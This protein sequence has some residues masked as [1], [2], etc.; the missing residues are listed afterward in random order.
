MFWADIVAKN[1]KSKEP[2]LV[3][4]AKTPS[5]KVHV[6]A[7]RGVLIHDFIHKSLLERGIKSRYT[8]HFDDFDPMDG[9]PVYLDKEKYQKF[10]GRPL[11]DIPSPFGKGSYSQYYANDF[12]KVFNKLG[13]KPEIIWA[14]ELYKNGIFDKAIKKVLDNAAEIQE[15]YH[16]ISGSQKL[17]NW[18]PFQPVCSKCKKIGT[19]LATNWD[20]KEVSFTCEKDLVVWA[21]GCGYTGKISPFKGNGKM[22]Y[23]VEWA[24]KWFILGITIEGAGKDHS[25]KGGTRDV[26]NTIMRKIFKKE[27]PEDIPYEHIL[28]GGRKMS[29][30]KGLGSS[31]SEVSSLLP[32]ELL[33]FLFARIPYQRAIDFDPNKP[34]TIPD[35]FDEFDRGRKAFFS[36]NSS[37]L[38]KTWEASQIASTSDGQGEIK[39]EFNLRFSLIKEFVKNLKTDKDILKEAQKLKKAKLT[40]TDEI[41]LLKRIK[42]VKI[43]L[44][45]LSEKKTTSEEIKKSNLSDKQKELLAKLSEEIKEQ[46]SADE[47]QNFIYNKGKDLGLKPAETFQAIYQVLIGKD[48]GPRAGILIKSAGISEVKKRFKQC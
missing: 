36:K 20:G 41:A 48:Q 4:D 42:Y 18:L 10:M 38:A 43:W 5:G 22:P 2:H 1:I 9:L 26:A 34:N 11:N 29:S 45:K 35:L 3:N 16:Q 28:F 47:L 31:A 15:I 6:G 14:S 12:I 30:S 19:T 40:K 32:P 8:Y 37:D 21:Q 7:L 23:K 46:M 25:S 13:A 27:P 33:R 44:E 24:A 17:K 39:E